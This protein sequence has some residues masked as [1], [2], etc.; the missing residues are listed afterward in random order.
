MS[1][2]LTIRL[3]LSKLAQ[4]VMLLTCILEGPSSN[5]AW[6]TDYPD[7]K[8]LQIS[9]VLSCRYQDSILSQAMPALIN[10]IYRS[11]FTIIQLFDN[12]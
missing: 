12:I 3:R 4:A 9:S 11:L 7:W 6:D 1:K 2:I 10:I 8:I 5:L